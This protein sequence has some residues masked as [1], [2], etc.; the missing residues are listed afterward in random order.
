MHTKTVLRAII[1]S[2]VHG[3]TGPAKQLFNKEEEELQE[4]AIVGKMPPLQGSEC[5]KPITSL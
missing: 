4:K 5:L 2:L 3:Q 1:E